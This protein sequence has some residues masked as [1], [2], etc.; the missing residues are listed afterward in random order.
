MIDTATITSTSRVSVTLNLHW[1][2]ANPLLFID[3]VA[4]FSEDCPVT[5]WT[6]WVDLSRDHTVVLIAVRRDVP[7][8]S[9]TDYVTHPT[10]YLLET[11]YE[12]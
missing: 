2:R 6:H 10:A 11:G 5:E 12:K 9:V 4:G 3:R 8:E 7:F 1:A